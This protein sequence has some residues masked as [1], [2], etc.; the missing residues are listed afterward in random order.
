MLCRSSP[1]ARNHPAS[2]RR[3]WAFEVGLNTARGHAVQIHK[4]QDAS[5]RTRARE[6]QP[7]R[8]DGGFTGPVSKYLISVSG[9]VAN[10]RT[11]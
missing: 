3:R 4:T 2:S 1:H 8:A 9:F 6:P 7:E 10:R 11:S 5:R